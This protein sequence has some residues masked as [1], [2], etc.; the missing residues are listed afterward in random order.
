MPATT[1][2]ALIVIGVILLK[3]GR[4]PTAAPV[5]ITIE[6]QQPAAGSGCAPFILGA[7]AMLL[8]IALLVP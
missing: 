7:V 1:I 8:L 5:V 4:P 2:L 3:F 6:P